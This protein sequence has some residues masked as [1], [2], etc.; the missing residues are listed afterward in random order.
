MKQ[1]LEVPVD[2]EKTFEKFKYPNFKWKW[3]TWLSVVS[4]LITF[5][6]FVFPKI[7]EGNIDKRRIILFLAIAIGPFILFSCLP[8]LFKAIRV[9]KER[10]KYYPQ[11]WNVWQFQHKNIAEMRT[12]MANLLQNAYITQFFEIEKAS[13]EKGRL[14][15]LLLKN[16][17]NDLKVEDSVEVIDQEDGKWMGRFKISEV[18][19]K[20]YYAY[21]IEQIDPVWLGYV[22]G[23]Q[24]LD[25]LPH[26]IAVRCVGGQK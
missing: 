12:E 6:F 17:K 7:N 25:V 10:L 8:W 20:V 2:I 3:G 18:R 13:F 4:T 24:E 11:I 26:M 23:K 22:I 16:K 5:I 21:G 15:I 1:R 14:Y 19:E 9:S